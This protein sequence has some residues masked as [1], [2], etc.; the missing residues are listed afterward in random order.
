VNIVLM[1]PPGAGKGTQATLIEARTELTHVASG[2]LFRP[3][4]KEQTD[5]GRT[6]KDYVDRGELVPD[7]LV[8][9]MIL[10]RITDDDCASG[11]VFDGF[12]RTREQAV[13]L[14]EALQERDDDIGAVIALT[15][16]REVLLKRLVGRQTCSLCGAAYNIFYSPSRLEAVCDLCHSDLYT[17]SDDTWATGRH[18]IDVYQEQTFPLLDFFREEELLHEID[19]TR[20]VDVV[21][22]DITAIV[23]KVIA[24]R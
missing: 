21:N 23:E 3:H 10:E 8:I 12:P 2:D 20:D 24:P 5:L 7:D 18:R 11:V 6:A 9:A 1:G 22:A 14:R 13:A 19:A 16:P 17:R 15:A 4:M